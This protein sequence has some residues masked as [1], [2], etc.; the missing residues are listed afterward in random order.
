[1]LVRVSLMISW[2]S[3]SKH[4][5]SVTATLNSETLMD[6][7]CPVFLAGL[8]IT[9]KLEEVDGRL[10]LVFL[11]SSPYSRQ[12]ENLST[13]SGL[14]MEEKVVLGDAYTVDAGDSGG[15]I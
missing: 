12:S 13:G 2:K 4:K 15:E 8:A 6:M 7:K 14:V 10:L 3:S 9:L 11:V 1:M 5:S